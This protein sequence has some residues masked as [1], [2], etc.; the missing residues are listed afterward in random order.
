[1]Q[2]WVILIKTYTKSILDEISLFTLRLLWVTGSKVVM[3][4][5]SEGL[6]LV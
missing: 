4:G 1:M 6:R 2:I 5:R 3:Y